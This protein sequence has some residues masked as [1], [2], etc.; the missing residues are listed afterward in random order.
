MRLVVV[1]AI[2]DEVV[3]LV[4]GDSGEESPPTPPEVN[5]GKRCAP[6]LVFARCR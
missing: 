4:E 2:L 5:T 1:A 3:V 6:I